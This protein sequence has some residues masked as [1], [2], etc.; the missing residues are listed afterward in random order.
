[1]VIRRGRELGDSGIR[2]AFVRRDDFPEKTVLHV[3]QCG[4]LIFGEPVALL[5]QLLHLT[6]A[7]QRRA[8]PCKVEPDLEVAQVVRPEPSQGLPVLAP[9]APVAALVVERRVAREGRDQS[10]VRHA[11]IQLEQREPLVIAKL[12]RGTARQLERGIDRAALG[13]V[14]ELIQKLRHEIEC[15]MKTRV[16][17]SQ[18]RHVVIVLQPVETHPRQ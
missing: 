18:R 6:P 13:V 17:R 16:L 11:E 14:V 5:E 7:F 2:Q 3:E 1:M 4:L 8:A 12:G 9:S 10:P 15:K